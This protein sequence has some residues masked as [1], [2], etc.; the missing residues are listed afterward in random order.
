MLLCDR[1]GNQARPRDIFRPMRDNFSDASRKTKLDD[2]PADWMAYELAVL[3]TRWAQLYTYPLYAAMDFDAFK[4]LNIETLYFDNAAWRSE[5]R[6]ADQST[7]PIQRVNPPTKAAATSTPAA[8]FKRGRQAQAT[9]GHQG[10][11]RQKPQQRQPPPAA[12]QPAAP[13]NA[14]PPA[15]PAVRS[16]TACLRHLLHSQDPVQFPGG[17]HAPPPCT[18]NHNVQLRN[19]RLAPQEKADI[20]ASL[21]VMKGGT[22]PA[23]ATK[24][25]IAHM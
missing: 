24:Y 9:G 5:C 21:A 19:G 14:K 4:K 16:Q 22:F 10:A 11:K 23:A 6:D 7:T 1:H 15:K 2:L 18:R 20:L 12:A 8:G 17:C 13:K 25:V 3:F